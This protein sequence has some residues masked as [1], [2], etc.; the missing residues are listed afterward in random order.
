MTLK[1]IKQFEGMYGKPLTHLSY[2]PDGLLF[3]FDD[4]Y[5]IMLRATDDE[6]G[7]EPYIIVEQRNEVV[8]TWARSL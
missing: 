8:E 2:T 5:V 6:H 3:V 7:R 1:H 4:Q